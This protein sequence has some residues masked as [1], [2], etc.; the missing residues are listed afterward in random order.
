MQYEAI[1]VMFFLYIDND[2]V[3]EMSYILLAV[4]HLYP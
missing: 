2:R 3:S 1:R 4:A